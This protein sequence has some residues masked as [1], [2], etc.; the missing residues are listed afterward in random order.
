VGTKAHRGKSFALRTSVGVD[1]AIKVWLDRVFVPALVRDFLA[2]RKPIC[3]VLS[4]T[5]SDEVACNTEDRE[6]EDSP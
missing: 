3:P 1:P 2:S 5:C 4:N 6:R